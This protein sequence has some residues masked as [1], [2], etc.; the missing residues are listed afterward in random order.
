MRG[1]PAADDPHLVDL[2]RGHMGAEL[3]QTAAPS[4]RPPGA[5][6]QLI[7]VETADRARVDQA[8]ASD[9]ERLVLVAARVGDDQQ[10]GPG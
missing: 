9:P 10:A 5:R 2:L 8:A 4:D 7:V 1:Q 6:Q 3:S